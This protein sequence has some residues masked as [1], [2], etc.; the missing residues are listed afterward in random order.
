MQ[1]RATS[2]PRLPVL[3]AHLETPARV[4]AG[5]IMTAPTDV[6]TAQ[7]DPVGPELNALGQPC[8]EALLEAPTE[9]K[10]ALAM[11]EMQ[12]RWGTALSS[13][14]FRQVCLQGFVHKHF[15][16]YPR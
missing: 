10:T 4:Q 3:T 5:R 13:A 6:D 11:P 12:S 14:L 9:H 8:R 16:Q 15:F 2:D 1:D 7:E